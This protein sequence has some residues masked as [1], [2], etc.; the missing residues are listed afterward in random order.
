MGCRLLEAI[1]RHS[2]TAIWALTAEKKLEQKRR[3]MYV[4]HRVNLVARVWHALRTPKY[5]GVLVEERGP[6]IEKEAC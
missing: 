2:F 1:V 6:T 5:L 3:L 4:A